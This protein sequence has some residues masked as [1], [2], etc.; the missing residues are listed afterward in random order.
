M[1]EA[2]L[3]AIGIAG[4]PLQLPKSY[5]SDKAQGTSISGVFSNATATNRGVP[6]GSI[7]GPLLFLIYRNDLP[8]CP[9]PFKYLLYADDRTIFTLDK[10]VTTIDKIKHLTE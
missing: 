1:L 10:R 6:Q 3:D 2:I 4:P 7:L 9:S 8:N 5:L